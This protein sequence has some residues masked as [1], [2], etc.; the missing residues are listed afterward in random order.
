M[1][2]A[3][4]PTPW[5]A[6]CTLPRVSD[7]EREL[8][9]ARASEAARAAREQSG[10][11]ADQPFDC[12]LT[13][14]EENFELAVIIAQLNDDFAGALVQRGPFSIALIGAT[15][16]P[17]RRRFTLAHEL[18][19]QQLGHGPRF[20]TAAKIKDE[21]DPAESSANRFAAEFIA[22][23]P[24]VERFVGSLDDSSPTLDLVCRVSNH[25]AFSPFAA[26]IRLQT[27]GLLT[28][29][30]VIRQLDQEIIN[31]AAR[32]CFERLSLDDR[33]DLC[34][35]PLSATP[36]LPAALQSSALADFCAGRIS[37]PQLADL[38]GRS[39]EQVERGL[40]RPAS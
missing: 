40:R 29:R 35:V 5:A 12:I 9:H 2:F 25:F 32:H 27:T 13:A 15:D 10:V 38:L 36:R 1:R 34:A 28:D 30:T 19:H 23:Q 24:A 14:I 4:K 26:R 6:R 18:G 33:E 11:A 37:A 3:Q 31:G 8:R 39:A 21:S 22:P 16:A 20:D 17:V 7:A